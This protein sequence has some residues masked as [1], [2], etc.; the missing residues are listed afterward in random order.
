VSEQVKEIIDIGFDNGASAAKL[1]GAGGSGF[2][3]VLFEER[4]LENLKEAYR[5]YKIIFPKITS[6]GSQIIFRESHEN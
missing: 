2:V 5:N 3:L 4:N 6:A 1:C